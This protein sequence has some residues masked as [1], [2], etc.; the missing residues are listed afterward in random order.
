MST[1]KKAAAIRPST[2]KAAQSA[3]PQPPSEA[4]KVGISRGADFIEAFDSDQAADA[5]RG[6]IDA[7]NERLLD[8]RDKAT[9]L[10]INAEAALEVLRAGA[11]S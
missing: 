1:K 9:N 11:T 6:F 8:A 5:I 3:A 2:G 10:T 7:V 4:Y